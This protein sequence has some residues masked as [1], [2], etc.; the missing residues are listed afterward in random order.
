MIHVSYEVA[1]G[2]MIIILASLW[3]FSVIRRRKKRHVS[4]WTENAMAGIDNMHEVEHR[5]LMFLMAQKTDAILAALSRTID[6]ERQKLG[7]VV[8]NP[9]MDEA[10]VAYQAKNMTRHDPAQPIRNAPAVDMGSPFTPPVSPAVSTQPDVAA[11]EPASGS[12]TRPSSTRPVPQAPDAAASSAGMGSPYDQVLQLSESGVD[13]RSI[14][15]QLK[16]PEAE[17]AMVLRLHA[18]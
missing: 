12:S 10:L 15:N 1:G 13:E 18:A 2:T 9:S 8:S 11:S 5:A 7:A 6:Q 14:A 16:L 3:L 4:G 17:V